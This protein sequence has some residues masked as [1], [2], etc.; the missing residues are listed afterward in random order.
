[1]NLALLE[2]ETGVQKCF[3]PDEKLTN[4]TQVDRKTIGKWSELVGIGRKIEE[5]P[6]NSD[7]ARRAARRGAQHPRQ[8]SRTIILCCLHIFVFKKV[9]RAKFFFAMTN[10]MDFD[11][12]RRVWEDFHHFPTVFHLSLLKGR[13]RL[14]VRS[15]SN[16]AGK[17]SESRCP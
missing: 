9:S 14:A 2:R 11:E 16:S 8:C 6:L 7:A 12:F 15:E 17:S 3:L 4:G 1:M 13:S 10:P 5:F